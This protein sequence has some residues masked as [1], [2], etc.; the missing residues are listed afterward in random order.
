MLSVPRHAFHDI[1]CKSRRDE[2]TGRNS[3]GRSG[4]VAA[5]QR[6]AKTW[7]GPAPAAEAGHVGSEPRSP[8]MVLFGLR[9]LAGSCCKEV[10]ILLVWL[11]DLKMARFD[12]ILHLRAMFG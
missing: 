11:E 8:H 1:P 7:P 12:L 3:R 6:A 10:E 4:P 5:C 2:R 9:L